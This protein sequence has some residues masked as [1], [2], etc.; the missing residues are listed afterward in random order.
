[1]KS[2]HIFNYNTDFLIEQI[3]KNHFIDSLLY[4]CFSAIFVVY[5]STIQFI[6]NLFLERV[7]L[8]RIEQREIVFITDYMRF[9]GGDDQR[10]LLW[11]IEESLAS[12][13]KPYI[14]K[15]RHY[16]NIFCL[17]FN[18]DSSKIFSGG[19]DENVIVHD[20]NT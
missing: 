11:K 12:I 7:F 16:S 10:V 17:G 4:C 3:K 1:M 15:N 14:M 19:N 2:Y 5:L 9:S 8:V 20:V 13:S 18:S 6:C